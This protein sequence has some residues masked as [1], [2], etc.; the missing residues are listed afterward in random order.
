MQILMPSGI[1]RAGTGTIAAN[2]QA[3]VKPAADAPKQAFAGALVRLHRLRDGY[4]DWHGVSDGSGKYVA[5]DLI[6]GVAYIPVAIDLSKTFEVVAAGPIMSVPLV[7][8]RVVVAQIGKA[9][10]APIRLSG[11]DYAVLHLDS[12]ILPAGIEYSVRDGFVSD[13]VSAA[14][15][16]YTLT[17]QATDGAQTWKADID[18]VV[19]A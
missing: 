12:G 4:L 7:A 8:P 13:N 11:R 18:V 15:G 1:A 5:S 17:M 19:Q 2:A 16:T 10:R 14:A 9:L 3:F 6:V